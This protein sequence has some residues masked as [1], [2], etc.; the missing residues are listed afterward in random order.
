MSDTACAKEKAAPAHEKTEKNNN[1]RGAPD[2]FNGLTQRDLEILSHAW[3]AMKTQ[4]EVSHFPSMLRRSSCATS[5]SSAS[6]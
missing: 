1:T 3:G 6:R 4:P 5:N 2:K